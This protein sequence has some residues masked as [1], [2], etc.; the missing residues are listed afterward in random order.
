MS[1]SDFV[2]CQQAP[3]PLS[4]IPGFHVGSLWEDL[5]HTVYLGIARDMLGSV[6][7]E[8][9][10]ERPD[11]PAAVT[12]AE[13]HLELQAYCKLNGLHC[14]RRSLSL[15][16][17]SWG[18][19]RATFPVLSSAVKAADV[20]TLIFWAAHATYH[21]SPDAHGRLRSTCVY[22]LAQF[23]HIL[24]S[25]GDL[26]SPESAHAACQAAYVYLR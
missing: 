14:P 4:F 9:V 26:M 8:F 7:A 18:S 12:L 19:G 6:L 25:S 5:L 2:R 11:V 3:S 23:L 1:H 24:D 17:I 21:D 16:I 20:K 13:K 10:E 15:K 22:G